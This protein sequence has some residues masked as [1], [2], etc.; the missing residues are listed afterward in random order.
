MN[1]LVQIIIIMY[2]GGQQ[3]HTTVG[4]AGGESLKVSG[5]IDSGVEDV[6]KTD[7]ITNTEK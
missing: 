2:E 4:T 5:I 1:I 7:E 6:V 3:R